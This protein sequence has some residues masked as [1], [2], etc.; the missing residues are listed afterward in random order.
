MCTL[1]AMLV[2]YIGPVCTRGLVGGGCISSGLPRAGGS[3]STV[4]VGGVRGVCARIS[5]LVTAGEHVLDFRSNATHGGDKV[6]IL[7]GVWYGMV[8]YWFFDEVI[9][10]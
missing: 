2:G 7:V 9:G 10:E 4:A 8:W 5:G 3:W 1:T 6:S